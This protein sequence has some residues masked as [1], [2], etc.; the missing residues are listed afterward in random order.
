MTKSFLSGEMFMK[1][2]LLITFMLAGYLPA[3]SQIPDR[4][5]QIEQVQTVVGTLV[6]KDRQT[7]VMLRDLTELEGVV[8]A[9]TEDSFYL[10]FKGLSGKKV[11]APVAYRDVLVIISKDTSLSFI[12]P[13]T[14][15]PF[16]SWNEVAEISYNNYLEIVLDDGRVVTGRTGQ[17]KKD[18][19]TLFSDPDNEKLVLPRDRI[20]YLY[21]IR[22]ES[23]KTSDGMAG[24]AKKGGKIGRDIGE[25]RS[26]KAFSSI[27]GTLIGAGIGALSGT[28]KDEKKFRVLIYSK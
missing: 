24:G 11:L 23:G 1:V 2:V 20:L 17:I 12:P 16:G 8:A 22:N 19:L 5:S 7:R 26:G 27:L 25:T 10:R 3:I 6:G 18:S 14:V 21:R 15:S 4:A 9:L 13:T 28:L